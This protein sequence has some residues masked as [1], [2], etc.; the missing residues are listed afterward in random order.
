LFCRSEDF[1]YGRESVEKRM[2]LPGVNFNNSNWKYIV[3]TIRIWSIAVLLA[4][5]VVWFASCFAALY[6]DWVV[7][8]SVSSGV[9]GVGLLISIFV[10]IYI[11]AKKYE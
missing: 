9:T 3:K 1:C 6:L 7:V 5:P 2:N 4:G 10:P 11:V 8:Y